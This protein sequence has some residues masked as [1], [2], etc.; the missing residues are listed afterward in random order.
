MAE[1]TLSLFDTTGRLDVTSPTGM[2]MTL[3]KEFRR[4]RRVLLRTGSI[5]VDAFELIVSIAL[6]RR[7]S[8]IIETVADPAFPLW[9]RETIDA[10][11]RFLS[12]AVESAK[13]SL[14]ATM[15]SSLRGA[16][17]RPTSLAYLK[18]LL[19]YLEIL[20]NYEDALYHA[21]GYDDSDGADGET[22][23]P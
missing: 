19:C 13:Q 1:T 15:A 16:A 7:H 21:V 22:E 23:A 8:Q 12:E 5:P 3:I 9:D 4:A 20:E 14:I 2:A 18:L 17:H 11:E 10:G 6:L